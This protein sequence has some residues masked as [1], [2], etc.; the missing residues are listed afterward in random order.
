MAGMMRVDAE[1]CLGCGV[2]VE[3]CPAG[4]IDLEAGKPVIAEQG[5][6]GCLKC[7]EACPNGALSVVTEPEPANLVPIP[8]SR[9]PA[10]AVERGERPAQIGGWAAAA[11]VLFIQEF[12]PRLAEAIVRS[13]DRPR[14]AP[15]LTMRPESMSVEPARPR[16]GGMRRRRRRRRGGAMPA[17]ERSA[18]SRSDG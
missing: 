3:A 4:L 18:R 6:D 8:S 7:V 14:S 2:C 10:T 11:M 16:F 12:A 15:A 17:A 13:L 5:C 9:Y 1:Q